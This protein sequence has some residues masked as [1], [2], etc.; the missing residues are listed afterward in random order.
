MT[1]L[2]LLKYAEQH[3]ITVIGYRLPMDKS[4]S[5]QIDK[6]C[7]IGIDTNKDMTSA[8]RATCLSHELGHCET[9]ALY[10]TFAPLAIRSRAEERANRWAIKKTIPRDE[11]DELLKKELPIWEIAEMFNVT[12]SFLNKAIEFYYE[13][14]SEKHA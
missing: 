8:E 9:G 3:D 12:E 7:F 10:Y 5:V 13:R 6:K 1:E 4:V 14:E 11:L 2:D